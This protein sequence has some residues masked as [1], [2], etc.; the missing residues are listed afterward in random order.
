MVFMTTKKAIRK[1][2]RPR[3]D[4]YSKKK[5]GYVAQSL[6]VTVE[7][8][9]LIRKAAALKQFSINLWITQTLIPIAKREIAAAETA[10][11]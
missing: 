5:K 11:T 8:A 3:P 4:R 2:A 9:K 6:R 10:T 7:E 1:S